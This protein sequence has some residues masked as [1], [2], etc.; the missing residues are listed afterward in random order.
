MAAPLWIASFMN[1]L[2]RTGLRHSDGL[3]GSAPESPSASGHRV[4]VAGRMTGGMRWILKTLWPRC[5]SV[6]EARKGI[7]GNNKHSVVVSWPK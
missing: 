5:G 2:R 3:E 1:V 7:S 4:S 6:L